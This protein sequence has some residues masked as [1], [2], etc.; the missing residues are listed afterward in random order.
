MYCPDHSTGVSCP[1][2]LGVEATTVEASSPSGDA[3]ETGAQRQTFGSRY[4]YDAARTTT[5]DVT[6]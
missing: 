4:D 5:Q 6:R 3:E 2:G 1:T